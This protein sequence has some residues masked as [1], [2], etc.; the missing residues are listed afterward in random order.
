MTYILANQY[1]YVHLFYT[2]WFIS[3]TT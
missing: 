1:N 2:S 3:Y